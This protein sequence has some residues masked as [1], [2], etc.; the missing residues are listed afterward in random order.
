[1][2]YE[3]LFK[4]TFA[5]LI[6]ILI[7]LAWF[8]RQVVGTAKDIN[9]RESINGFQTYERLKPG[10]YEVLSIREAYEGD[11]CRLTVLFQGVNG[12][13]VP[14]WTNHQGYG[15][16]PSKAYQTLDKLTIG[17]RVSIKLDDDDKGIMIG[18]YYG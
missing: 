6:V 14:V 5:V 10:V 13:R 3:S 11:M 16:E 12:D 15:R 17:D 18:L 8:L 2:N 9:R 4:I 1:M 7:G